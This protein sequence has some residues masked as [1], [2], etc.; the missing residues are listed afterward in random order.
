MLLHH[1]YPGPGFAAAPPG[2][3]AGYPPAA[4]LSVMGPGPAGGKR[5]H[6]RVDYR[7]PPG[8]SKRM[9]T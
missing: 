6:D 5:P 2:Y 4:G 7:G 9:R 8:D 3:A 1:I